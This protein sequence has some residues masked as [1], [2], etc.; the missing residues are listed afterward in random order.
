MSLRDDINAA[1][2]S[3]AEIRDDEGLT[4]GEKR[5]DAEGNVNLDGM[6]F[7]F[8]GSEASKPIAPADKDKAGEGE[9]GVKAR[10]AESAK[11]DEPATGTPAGRGKPDN[12]AQTAEPQDKNSMKAPL[13]WSPKEREDWSRIP[14]HLQEKITAREKHINEVMQTTADARRT[15]ADMERLSATYGA[16]M[17]GVIAGDTP[18]QAVENLMSTVAGLR[19]GTPIQKAQI[20]ADL[21]N[22][23]GV[24]VGALDTALSGQ[25]PDPNDQTAVLER[26]LEER[27]APLQQ[28]FGNAQTQEQQRTAQLQTAAMDEVKTFAK[29]AEFLN[30]VRM[31]MADLIDMAAKRG[32]GLTLQEAYDKACMLNP[33][34][35]SIIR[36]RQ[37][38]QHQQTMQQKRKAASSVTGQQVGAGGGGT[39]ASLRDSIA[40]AWDEQFQ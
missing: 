32:V 10:P 40:S 13:D 34:V 2:D 30:D 33:E 27:L 25:M 5:V 3:W 26:M 19:M 29:D 39:P 28:Y 36:Q 6:D 8:E 35:S 12:T 20:V 1:H 17:Q 21:V 4:P 11:G 9:E 16:A 38:Q 22:V 18:M 14:R 23:F 15:H 31:E 37:Q 7:E 24:D